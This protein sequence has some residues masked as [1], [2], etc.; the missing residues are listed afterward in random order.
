MKHTALSAISLQKYLPRLVGL[1]PVVLVLS[2][3]VR[4]G[5]IVNKHVPLSSTAALGSIF[6]LL[7]LVVLWGV[8][9]LLGRILMRVYA[10]LGG[11]PSVSALKFSIAAIALTI[12]GAATGYHFGTQ[13]GQVVA[14]RWQPRVI[15]N[16]EGLVRQ[17][18]SPGGPELSEMRPTQRNWPHAFNWNS[19]Q[20]TL[21]IDADRAVSIRVPFLQQP[22]SYKPE[23]SYVSFIRVQ[24]VVWH[25]NEYLAVLMTLRPTSQRSALAVFDVQGQLIYEE[26]LQRCLHPEEQQFASSN[27]GGSQ[28]LMVNHC[29][30]FTL[31]AF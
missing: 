3:S 23:I 26:L 29:H 25:D 30:A 1:L 21:T 7:V 24:P 12:A 31:V 10:K 28:M 27:V 6:L 9:N 19:E 20:A 16:S 18:L 15:L 17:T 5:S 22:I 4:E 14:E 8:G 13:V 2:F 11:P